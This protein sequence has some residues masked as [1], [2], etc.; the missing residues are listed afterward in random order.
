ML[1][2]RV[3]S[4]GNRVVSSKQIYE[5]RNHHAQIRKLA[6]V[7]SDFIQE[8]ATDIILSNKINKWI[9]WLDGLPNVKQTWKARHAVQLR[10]AGGLL[11]RRIE[12]NLQEEAMAAEENAQVQEDAA[13]GGPNAVAAA[14]EGPAAVRRRIY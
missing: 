12:E 14:A 3:R 7:A 2:R 11:A 10:I 1:G 4:T 9:G 13:E 8:D 6:N 5:F